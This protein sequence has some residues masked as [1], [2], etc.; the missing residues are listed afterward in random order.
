MLQDCRTEQGL[1]VISEGGTKR[2]ITHTL[3]NRGQGPE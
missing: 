2:V 3:Q 1:P